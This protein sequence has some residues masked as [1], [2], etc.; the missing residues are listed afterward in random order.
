[1][2]SILHNTD[3]ARKVNKSEIREGQIRVNLGTNTFI[4]K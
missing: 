3:V 4:L 2:F 1:M